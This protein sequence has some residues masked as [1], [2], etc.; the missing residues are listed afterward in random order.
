[1][2]NAVSLDKLVKGQYGKINDSPV[3][4]VGHCRLGRRRQWVQSNKCESINHRRNSKAGK[5]RVVGNT[6]RHQTCVHHISPAF[7]GPASENNAAACF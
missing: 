3:T 1:M 7:C 5:K 2:Y 6:L 4:A